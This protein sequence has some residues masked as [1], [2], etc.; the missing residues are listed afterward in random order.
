M[1]IIL[2]PGTRENIEKSI[3]KPVSGS[4]AKEYL[5]F[6]LIDEIIT[7]AGI[8]GIRCWG[9]TKTNIK[10][11]KDIEKGDE[12][13][14]SEK[15]TGLFNYYGVVINK[16][17]NSAFGN[18]LWPVVGQN[19][20]ENIYFLANITK[21]TISK[22]NLLEEIG[23]SKNFTLGGPIRLKNSNYLAL[24]TISQRFEIPI[25]DSVAEVNIANDF[26]AENIQALGN[27]R[28]GHTKFSK[29]VK[30]NYNYSCAICGINEAEFLIAGHISSWAEDAE[31]RINPKNGICLCSLHDKAFEHGYI[32][33]S[34]NY[35]VILNRKIHPDSLLYP[36]LKKYENIVINIPSN[37]P[38][39]KFFLANHRKKHNLIENGN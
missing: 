26:S 33:L 23:Y 28:V 4:F 27:R 36:H 29:E 17:Q 24:S 1:S 11:F 9:L 25:F 19:P 5:S 14:I 2:A 18:A 34:D 6:S 12:V 35:R 10:L 30:G 21:V 31:N 20:W 16:T 39:D 7:Y 32:G 3:A 38:P 37:N 15:D 22:Q 13:L 8:E